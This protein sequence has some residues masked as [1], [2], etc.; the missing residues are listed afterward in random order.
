[1]RNFL[2]FVVILF[3]FKLA[4]AQDEQLTSLKFNPTLYGQTRS[5]NHRAT[6]AKYLVSKGNT[7]VTTDTLTLPFVDDFSTNRQ[8]SVFWL[9]DHTI[10]S[11]VNAIGGCL[12]NEG[13]T[14][15]EGNFMPTQSWLYSWDIVHQRLDSIAQQP[16]RFTDFGTLPSGC[17]SSQPSTHLYWPAYYTYTF[18]SAFGQPNDSVLVTG[19]GSD[20]VISITYA[21]KVYVAEGE[22]GTLWFDNFAYINNTYPIN[23]PTIG[24]ATLDG[25]NEFGEPYNSNANSYGTA[26]YLTS[27]PI[28]LSTTSPA[29]SVYLSFFFE[30]QGL[31]DYP[32]LVDSLIV[33]FKDNSGAWRIVWSD[34][35]N[36]DPFAVPDTFRQVMIKV[37]TLTIPYSYYFNTFQFRFRN[38]ASLYGNNNHWHIDY[39]KM[40]KN[41]SFSDTVIHDMA[42]VYPFPSILKNYT[43]LPAV[44]FN[45]PDDL[46]DTIYLTV[47]NLDP[48]AYT[49]PPATNFVQDASQTYPA[50]AVVLTQPL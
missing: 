44:Q 49:N 45:N 11:F 19:S 7:I 6:G 42:F 35:G 13:V 30:P 38:K 16:I 8:P 23:P 22:H 10:D 26:D 3:A 1:M 24:V 39:V 25:L 15:I 21:P 31:G 36:L 18:D 4:V 5:F 12:I 33:E 32:D 9:R 47:H 2:P 34:T 14:T 37:D 29:D 43:Q 27:N 28:D 40:D 50:Q 41:R 17:F 48:N 46:V 20:T